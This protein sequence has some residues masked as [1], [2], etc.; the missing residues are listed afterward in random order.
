VPPA[1]PSWVD[2]AERAVA[3]AAPDSAP[4]SADDGQNALTLPL[5]PFLAQVHGQLAEGTRRYLPPEHADPVRVA[6]SCT[7]VLGERLA[8]ISRRTLAFELNKALVRAPK[9]AGTA[10]FVTRLCT[11]VGLAALLGE[12]PVLGRLLAVASQQA[13]EACLELLGRFAADRAAIVGELLGGTDPG[14]VVAIEP[15]LGDPHQRGRTVAAVC[16]TDG[17]KV[18]YKPRPMTA[19]IVFRRLADWLNGLVPAA[20]LRMPAVAPRAG[21]G[22]LEFVA[23]QPLRGPGAAAEFYWRAGV[24]L[25]ALYATHAADMHSE[26]LIAN[27]TVPVLVDVETLFHPDLPVP[28]TTS[29]DPA[30]EALGASVYRA[31]L[32]PSVTIDENGAF[33]RSGMGGKDRSSAAGNRPRLGGELAE[34]ADHEQALLAGF[35]LGYDA[36]AAERAAFVRLIDGCG[37]FEVRTVARPTRGYAR[38]IDETAHPSLL[39]DARDLDRALDVLRQASAHHPL[40]A[41]LTPHELADLWNGD[42]PLLTSRL[43]GTD[44]WTSSGQRLPGVLDRSGLRC[45]LDKVAAMGEADRRD[46]EW[47]ISASLA[48]Q[49]PHDGH[50]D[51]AP[52]RGTVTAAA[53]DP[54][55]LLAAACGL[56]D[57][58]GARASSGR[59]ETRLGRVNWLVLQLVED[60]QWMMLPMGAGLADGYLGVALF[61]AQLAALTGID[62]YADLARQAVGALPPLLGSLEGRPELVSAIGCGGLNGL[63]GISYGLARLSRLLHDAELGRWAVAAAEL[64]GTAYLSAVPGWAAGSAGFLAAMAAVQTETGS[65]LVGGLAMACADHL[66]E[67]AERTAGRCVPADEPVPAGFAHGPAGVGWAL[68][69]FAAAVAEPRYLTAG[70]RAAHRAVESSAA[71]GDSAGWCRGSAG[72]LLARTCLLAEVGD[73]DSAAR[74][75][76]ER[77]VLRDLSPCHGELGIAETLTVLAAVTR[78]TTAHQARRHRAGLILDVVSRQGSY[79]GTPGGISSP[80]MLNGLAGIGYGL[81]RLGF[82]EQVPSM[83]LLDPGPPTLPPPGKGATNAEEKR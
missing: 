68:T 52:M 65:R 49:R 57:E 71:A 17:R 40:W 42:I 8:R 3:A 25:A 31:G 59:E 66:S 60:Q 36:I 45:A 48:V 80:G 20:G 75:L 33:D 77:P 2:V 21:Y 23:S 27:G 41:A 78:S 83:L 58:I 46:Q 4:P 81:L 76:S 7:A 56:A 32:L 38:L 1:R 72:L 39:R 12:Y 37:D 51:A 64:A 74:A 11:P 28:S 26:N 19:H 18:I 22:W 14:P 50:R 13:A 61:L 30:A 70:R 55:R 29:V 35:R 73:L 44:I 62:R 63:G 69:R 43:S 67:L 5:R 6:G 24:L 53:A 79:C 16:F 9:Q 82:A 15:G 47:V 34:P 54:G 10:A